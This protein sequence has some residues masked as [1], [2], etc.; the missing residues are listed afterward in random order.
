MRSTVLVT[1]L[2]LLPAAVLAQADPKV[3]KD[4][5][6]VIILQGYSCGKAVSADKQGEDD[7]I[8]RCESGDRY[9]VTVDKTSDRVVVKKL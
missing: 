7:Y 4:L 9:R 6:T 8:V 2:A 5:G 3:L 1:V